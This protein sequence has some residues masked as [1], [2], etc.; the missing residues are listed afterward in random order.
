MLIRPNRRLLVVT[1]K[2]QKSE[3]IIDKIVKVTFMLNHFTQMGQTPVSLHIS[4]VCPDEEERTDNLEVT[5]PKMIFRNV[6]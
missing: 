4:T 1:E 3:L 5:N 6:S 2:F